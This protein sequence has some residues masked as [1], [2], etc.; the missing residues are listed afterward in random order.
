[1]FVMFVSNGSISKIKIVCVVAEIVC[2]RYIT[3]NRIKLLLRKG[4]ETN[5]AVIIFSWYFDTMFVMFVSN[6]SISK[7]KIVCEEEKIRT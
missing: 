1:M 7:I 3:K 2:I 6:D 4:T 5:Q